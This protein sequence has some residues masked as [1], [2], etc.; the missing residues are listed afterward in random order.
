MIFINIK[1]E[2]LGFYKKKL[3]YCNGLYICFI[4]FEVNVEILFIVLYGEF[5]R[6]GYISKLDNCF[7]CRIVLNWVNYCMIE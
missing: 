1:V 2:V 6:C 5:L 7:F 4:I 3:F